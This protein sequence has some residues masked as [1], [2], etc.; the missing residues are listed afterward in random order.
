MWFWF[1]VT[2]GLAVVTGAQP[3]VPRWYVGYPPPLHPTIIYGTFKGRTLPIVGVAGQTP[4]VEV[5]GALKRLGTGRKVRFEPRRG[6]DYAP[7][8]VSLR[9]LRASSSRTNLVLMFSNGGQVS[10]GTLNARS[11]F[12]A[13]VVPTQDYTDCYV[14]IVFFDQAYLDG[15]TPVH[16]ASV[17]FARIPDLKAGVENEVTLNFNYID[18]TGGRLGFFPLFF[19]RGLEIRSDQCLVVAQFFRRMEDRLHDALVAAYLEKNAGKSARPEAYLRIPPLFLGAD[20]LDRAPAEAEVSFMV[21]EEGRVENLQFDTPLPGGVRDVL[22]R[23][24]GAWLFFPR[25]SEGRPARTMVR[26]P[27]SLKASAG[28]GGADTGGEAAAAAG[29]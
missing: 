27:L 5:D 20:D 15:D 14:A 19:T 25:L 21:S 12:S 28:N 2:C 11:D 17:Q 24:L 9:N 22:H 8:E 18:N 1:C 3:S 10:G 29:N 23:T 7:G 13:T 4:Q 16:N 6:S 26:M